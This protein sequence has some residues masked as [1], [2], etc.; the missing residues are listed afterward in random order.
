MAIDAKKIVVGGK[1]FTEST[2][3]SPKETARV[4]REPDIEE[5]VT[6]TTA[7]FILKS[8][9]KFHRDMIE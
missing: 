7:S 8:S 2:K 6:S 5:E 3:K 4:T 1:S 9:S